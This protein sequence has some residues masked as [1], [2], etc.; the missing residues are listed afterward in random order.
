MALAAGLRREAGL[1]GIVSLSSYLPM[2]AQ[3]AAEITPAGRAT[4]VFQGHGTQDPMVPL[5]LGQRSKTALEALKVPVEWHSYPMG[6]SVCPE[7]VADLRRWLGM[8]F[9]GG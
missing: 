6:H 8:R 2:A 5:S 1:A 3:T 4:P 9:A 7:E